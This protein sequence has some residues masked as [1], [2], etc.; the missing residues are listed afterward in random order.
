[1]LAAALA[2][3]GALNRPAQQLVGFFRAAGQ[4]VIKPVAHRVFDKAEGRCG[5]ELV[6]GLA[7]KLRP[8]DEDRKEQTGMAHNVFGGNLGRLLVSRQ[9]SK[10]AQAFGDRRA[11]TRFMRSAIRGR[12]S[13]T[14]GS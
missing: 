7:N 3:L 5:R 6:L 11:E 9:L 14:V 8:L 4:P 10:I 12:N 13:V 1:M 2:F